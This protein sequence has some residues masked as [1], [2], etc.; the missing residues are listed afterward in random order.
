MQTF[1][2][3][4]KGTPRAAG[5]NTDDLVMAF[6]FILELASVRPVRLEKEP[7][8]VTL[9]DDKAFQEHV[10]RMKRWKISDRRPFF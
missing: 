4:S 2:K 1:V 9:W 3:D 10:S 5:K 8:E 6:L 7:R